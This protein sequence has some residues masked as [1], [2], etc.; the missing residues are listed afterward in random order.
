MGGMS[1]Y[2]TRE[3]RRLTLRNE[4]SASATYPGDVE[5]GYG[6]DG[7]QRRARCGRMRSSVFHWCSRREGLRRRLVGNT[8]VLLVLL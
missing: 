7:S 2:R 5:V 4:K 1:A 3:N 6:N 8:E